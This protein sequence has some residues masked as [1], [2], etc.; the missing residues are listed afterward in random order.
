MAIVDKNI[1]IEGLKGKL[2]NMLVFRQRN[3]KTV[4][5]VAP[6][7]TDKPPS[8]AQLSRRE[9]FRRAVVYAQE[10]LQNPSL[11]DWYAAKR[12][13]HQSVYHAALSDYMHPP[14]IMKIDTQS[15]SGNEGDHLYIEVA[16][17]SGV[18]AVTVTF[19]HPDGTLA[20]EGAALPGE[21]K[22]GWVYTAQKNAAPWQSLSLTVRATDKPG[23]VS[24]KA[25]KL[26]ADL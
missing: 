14:Q 24:E 20:E 15:Y 12:L 17:E 4:V 8:E 7:K 13:H 18:T 2:G 3:G 19:Y 21:Q 26:A 11:K 6:Q 23:H 1:I 16:E 10:V 9:R 22:T 5:S 25:V